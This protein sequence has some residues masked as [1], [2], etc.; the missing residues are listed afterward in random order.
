MSPNQKDLETQIKSL[1]FRKNEPRWVIEIR[2]QA[3][4]KFFDL[5]MPNWGA[6]IAKLD[7]EKMCYYSCPGV[8]ACK[9]WGQVPKSIKIPF[10]SSGVQKHENKFG[11]TYAQYESEAIYLK[12]QV[13]LENQGIKFLRIEDGLRK[14]P[15]LFKK[16]F[17]Y[18]I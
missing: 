12:T 3:L 17:Y 8:Q 18:V 1:S 15:K 14:F 7:F 13:T 6:D 16:Y 9:S 10:D 4:E 11:G 5:K 2:L